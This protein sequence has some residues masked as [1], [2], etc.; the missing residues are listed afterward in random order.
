MP[1]AGLAG[2]LVEAADVDRA[3]RDLPDRL[4]GSDPDRWAVLVERALVDAL[5][6]HDA[7]AP[8]AEVGRA[9]ARLTR[10]ARVAQVADEV[11]LSRRH[12]G[13]LLRAEA[14]VTPKEWQRR[15][16]AGS[17]DQ[18]EQDGRGRS[19]PLPVGAPPI[20]HATT[21]ERNSQCWPS[22]VVVDRRT[23]D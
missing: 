9:L 21:I 8:R 14:G 5:A 20:R 19:H 6:R 7:Q 18:A 17:G 2:A 12:L 13:E 3:L 11:G 16:G 22:P 4:A 10:G 1:A 15:E 23:P